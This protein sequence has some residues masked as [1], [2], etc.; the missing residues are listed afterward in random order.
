M[1]S[2]GA[3]FAGAAQA[4]GLDISDK[5][6]AVGTSIQL[7]RRVAAGLRRQGFSIKADVRTDDVGVGVRPGRRSTA[8][9]ETRLR[10]GLNRAS[11]AAL[12]RKA[13]GSAAG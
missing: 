1:Q 9:L 3:K 5:S 6:V 10:L 7:A 8:T 12:L 11:R 13:A 2:S 4:K